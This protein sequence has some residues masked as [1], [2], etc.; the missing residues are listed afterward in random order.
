MLTK[1]INNLF[2]SS[3]LYIYRNLS[4]AYDEELF[5]KSCEKISDELNLISLELQETNFTDKMVINIVR[6][7]ILKLE[8]VEI[9]SLF[10]FN[11]PKK[12]PRL[13][14]NLMLDILESFDKK[15]VRGIQ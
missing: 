12:A 7:R 14:K 11:D 6:K 9:K 2:T 3:S 1:I 5:K 4:N 15:Y 8:Q 13:A 10:P